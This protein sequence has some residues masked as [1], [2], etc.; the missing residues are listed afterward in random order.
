M[1]RNKA[2]VYPKTHRAV[3]ICANHLDNQYVVNIEY[4]RSDRWFFSSPT[5]PEYWFWVDTPVDKDW[6]YREITN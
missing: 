6:D 5:Q 2:V 4:K 3:L 1:L